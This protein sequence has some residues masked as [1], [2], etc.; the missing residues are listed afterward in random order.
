MTSVCAPAA[1][2]KDTT[3][4]PASEFFTSDHWKVVEARMLFHLTAA[5]PSIFTHQE[6][7]EVVGAMLRPQTR[8]VPAGAVK[9]KVIRPVVGRAV[10]LLLP[11]ATC[12]NLLP[13]ALA[14]L[15]TCKGELGLAPSASSQIFWG[16]APTEKTR[17]S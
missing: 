15:P 14:S 13:E 9:L 1:R 16:A 8:Y 11:A 10:L 12:T 4:S 7:S 3:W 2:S 6:S 5:R 17:S